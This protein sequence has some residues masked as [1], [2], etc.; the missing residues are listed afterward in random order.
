MYALILVPSSFSIS[1]FGPFTVTSTNLGLIEYRFWPTTSTFTFAGGHHGFEGPILKGK[2]PTGSY[3]H[4]LHHRYFVCNFGE[5]T[6]PLDKLFGT[7]H[8]GLPGDVGATR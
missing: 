1:I 6:L 2:L 8:D 4:Y 3:F 7:F 5:S